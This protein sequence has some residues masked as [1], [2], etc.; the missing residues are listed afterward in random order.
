MHLLLS[1]VLLIGQ[2]A[3]DDTLWTAEGEGYT[4]SI[5]YPETALENETIGDRLEEYAQSQVSNFL[6]MFD[7]YYYDELPM[8]WT[9]EKTFTQ[10]DSPDGMVCMMAWTY[11]YSGGAHGNTWTR[12]FIYDEASGSFLGPVEL[13]GGEEQF[14]AFAQEVITQLTEEQ[15]DDGWVEEGASADPENYHSLVPV[16]DEDGK[17]A[18]YTVYFPPY[19]VACYACGVIEAYVPADF[20]E[21]TDAS[22]SVD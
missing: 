7:E 17:I 9:H 12:S 4:I 16:P 3:P 14:R 8:E 18:G 2:G 1:A 15:V 20:M 11:E 13:L 5:V 10:E 6:K 21:V 19:Q 22:R